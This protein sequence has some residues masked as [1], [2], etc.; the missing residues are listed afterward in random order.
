VGFEQLDTTKAEAKVYQI[1]SLTLLSFVPAL[2]LIHFWEVAAGAQLVTTAPYPVRIPGGMWEW[3]ALTSLNNLADICS[4]ITEKTPLSSAEDARRSFPVLSPRSSPFRQRPQSAPCLH[5]GGL[6]L[7]A[8]KHRKTAHTSS[9]N[10]PR[11]VKSRAGGSLAALPQIF[12]LKQRC[13]GYGLTSSERYLRC[14][15]PATAPLAPVLARSSIAEL[16]LNLIS[17]PTDSIFAIS[18]S[19]AELTPFATK[20]YQS[21]S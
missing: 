14:V 21:N 8:R 16:R 9:R 17:Q 1:E 18:L 10:R 7:P 5:S 6:S 13:Q 15:A 3:S 2:T 12:R 11:R 19:V 4:N 20:P